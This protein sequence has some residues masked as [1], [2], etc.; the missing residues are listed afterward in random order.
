M[1]SRRDFGRL[2]LAASPLS[3]I[4]VSAALGARIDSSV[5]GVKLGAITYSFRDLPRTAG[6]DNV[7][8][9][10][11]ALTACGM[12]EIELYSPNIE[13]APASA[14]KPA[15]A[16]PA[17]GVARGARTPP[18]PE[19]IAARKAE[20][21]ALRQ[22]RISTPASY[23]KTVRSKFDAAGINVFAYTLGFNADFTDDEIEAGFAQ[24]KALGVDLIASSTTLSMAQRVA[25][26]ADKH[27]VRVAVHGYANV[28]DPNQF[29]SPESF[30]KALAMSKYMRVN[31]DIG[32]FTAANY[33]AVAYIRENHENITHLHIKDRK[34]ND[35]TNEPFGDGDTPIK[36]VLVLIRD[37]KW[38]LRAFV[39][40][41]YP[42][43]GNSVEEV[44]KCLDYL[45]SCLA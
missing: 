13:P 32:H 44:K 33:D 6:Q 43:M 14:V 10:I 36:P 20:R 42:G 24:A 4:P 25:P 29:G 18:T 37:N 27:Q 1:Y 16:G 17:Y 21:E 7:D 11:K 26:F 9:V 31:L 8:D 12:G 2:A 28:K 30:A 35:G 40:Y 41:E 5:N 34:R 3:L 38:P 45:R 23:Y 22:W 39:E 15:V 19:Q